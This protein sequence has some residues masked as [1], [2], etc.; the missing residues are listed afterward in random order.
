MAAG[1]PNPPAS[2]SGVWRV[3]A[4]SRRSG[5]PR[6][7]GPGPRGQ[8]DPSAANPARPWRPPRPGPGPQGPAARRSPDRRQ[9]DVTRR[10]AQPDRRPADG[11]RSQAPASTPCPA[12]ACRQPRKP[13]AGPWPPQ[14]AGSGRPGQPRNDRGCACPAPRRQQPRRRVAGRPGNLAGPHSRP[15]SRCRAANA[16]SCSDSIPATLTTRN[17]LVRLTR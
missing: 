6:A 13:P 2:S 12:T 17:P 16:Q 11:P 1:S 15:Q 3:V 10:S 14:I 8:P 7:S 4:C 9:A 5:L